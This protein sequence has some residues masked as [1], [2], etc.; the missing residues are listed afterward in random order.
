MFERLQDLLT[1]PDADRKR[2]H[3]MTEGPLRIG[4]IVA[5]VAFAAAL[6]VV[7]MGSWS[8]GLLL[9]PFALGGMWLARRLREQEQVSLVVNLLLTVLV[10]LIIAGEAVGGL[11]TELSLLLYALPIIIA[12]VFI[13]PEAGLIWAGFIFLGI[14]LRSTIGAIWGSVPFQV[15]RFTLR[16]FGVGFVALIV[17]NIGKFNAD[18][19]WDLRRRIQYGLAGIEIGRDI[20]GLR[21]VQAMAR[22]VVRLVHAAF[23]YYHVGIYLLDPD[24]ET[25]TL[26]DDAGAELPGVI[27]EF[28]VSISGDTGVSAAVREKK[29]LRL[30]NWEET[31]DSNGKLINFTYHRLPHFPTRSEL[32]IP[33]QIRER[34]LGA[35][36]LHSTEVDPFT[37]DII[38]TLQG[39]AGNFANAL[40]TIRLL[41]D[42]QRR[43]D[44][45]AVLYEETQRRA[46]YVETTAQLAQA[47]SSLLD[48]QE[49][50]ERAVD[51]V[52]SGLDLYQVGIFLI[53]DTEEWAVLVAASS[54]GG[55][56]MLAR[57]HR[58]RIGRQGIVGWAIANESPRIALDVGED[59]VHFDS[60][61]LPETRSEMALP[62]MVRDNLLGALDVQS[63]QASAF[64]DEDVSVLQ[65][66]ADQIAVAIEN[67][68]LFQ[69]SREALQEMEAL[70]RYYVAQQWEEFLQQPKSLAAEYRSL[71]VTPLEDEWTE[72][73]E[74]ALSAAD[75]VIERY[76]TS[77]PASA[78]DTTPVSPVRSSLAVPIRLQDEVIGVLEL[79]E[80]DEARKWTEDEVNMANSVVDQLALALENARLFEQT[81][82]A[83]SE[84]EM[85][86][87]ATGDLNLAQTYAD[88]LSAL[89]KNTLLEDADL[90]VSLNLFDRPWIGDDMPELSIAVAR[91]GVLEDSQVQSRYRL[92]DFPVAD[93]LLSPEEATLI[94]NVATDE[95]LDGQ[96]RALYGRQFGAGSTLFI[97]LV[98]G[99]QW[100]GYV[101]GI[102]SEPQSFEEEAVRRLMSLARQ[103]AVA[104]QNRYQL[105]ATAARAR[106]ERLIRE[107]VGQIQKAPDV[108]SVLQMATRELGQALQA[109]K[110]TIRLGKG[111]LRERRKLGTGPLA[112]AEEDESQRSQQGE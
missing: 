56:K 76:E 109:K 112:D 108:E 97:P 17:W 31:V 26:V 32:V 18:L 28:E 38:S 46:R 64:T 19:I 96:T 11:M 77:E 35:I 27:D 103:A 99:G 44:E 62:L 59:A 57:G 69:E 87:E 29:V 66:L 71:G 23:G 78:P 74:R 80:T 16:M 22:R 4:F 70:Q 5:W 72:A 105:A 75:P 81:Q 84:T 45:L 107:I 15:G 91:E 1:I 90:N 65:T 36:D 67:A 92:T 101:N 111:R 104:V 79:Q 20:S 7:L 2:L 40:G 55:K 63:K 6:I 82:L 24:E 43:H 48:P 14:L 47:I 102:Y 12:A 100:I 3:T 37:D 106:R 42:V 9:A 30:V 110:A 88:I 68:R 89:K 50:L 86:Y 49:L 39:L 34:V 95:R 85:L 58:L 21:N 8:Y 25:L 41:D 98:V 93:K 10:V 60:P 52:S 61:D 51:L 94:E 33:L 54:E 83:L 13:T 53:D 73:M